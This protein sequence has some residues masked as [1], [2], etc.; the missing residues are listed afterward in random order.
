MFLDIDVVEFNDATAP[1][2]NIL[3][4]ASM[5]RQVQRISKRSQERYTESRNK[6]IEDR[7]EDPNVFVSD[8]ED[9]PMQGAEIILMHPA[10]G[11]YY[12][13]T[14]FEEVKRQIQEITHR[15]KTA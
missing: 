13:V 2:T 11:A 3:L 14:P 7:E 4:N 8:V 12:T 9:L 5:V 6:A 15:T 1:F 10:M